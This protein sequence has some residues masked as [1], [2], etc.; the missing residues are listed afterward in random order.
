MAES[1]APTR[2]INIYTTAPIG[3]KTLSRPP[4]QFITDVAN[5][6]LREISWVTPTYV[7]S[8]HGGSGSKTGPYWVAS[9]VNVIGES[10]YWNSSA[11]FIFWDDYGGWYDSQPPAY[12]DYDGLGARL[13]LLNRGSTATMAGCD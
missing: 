12:V 8:D 1:G 11:I 4:T 6:K 5:G 9:L 13:P 2:R 7:N 10:Q 3:T